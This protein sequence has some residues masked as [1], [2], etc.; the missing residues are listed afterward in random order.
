VIGAENGSELLI[1]SVAVAIEAL[2]E[3]SGSGPCYHRGPS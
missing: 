2:C 3:C 1:D